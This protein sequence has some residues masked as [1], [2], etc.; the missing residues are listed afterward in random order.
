L[1]I[2]I[3][4]GMMIKF[5]VL[6]MRDDPS[7]QSNCNHLPSPWLYYRGN[8]GVLPGFYA[9]GPNKNYQLFVPAVN[10]YT[11]SIIHEPNSVFSEC[12]R[13]SFDN[14]FS[15]LVKEYNYDFKREI[16][17]IHSTGEIADEKL[18]FV[19]VITNPP[20]SLRIVVVEER[21]CQPIIK[22]VGASPKCVSGHFLY[23]M[24]STEAFFI[25]AYG[26]DKRK[27]SWTGALRM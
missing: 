14:S 12:P 23:K 24:N 20:S 15:K 7:H 1:N 25:I 4:G 9:I 6:D 16:V 21:K 3:Y 13:V 26:D 22:C 5:F 10:N 2:K 18:I 19:S 11:S 27:I 17:E 8:D